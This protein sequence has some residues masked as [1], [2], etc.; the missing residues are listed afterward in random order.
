[1]KK[2]VGVKTFKV[3]KEHIINNKKVISYSFYYLL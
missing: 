2:N 3:I 1:M